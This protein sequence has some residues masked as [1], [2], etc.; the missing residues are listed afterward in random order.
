MD[1]FAPRP[2]YEEFPLLYRS[3]RIHLLFLGTLDI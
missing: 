2:S 1:L 3:Y